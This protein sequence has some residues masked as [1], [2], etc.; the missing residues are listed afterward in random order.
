MQMKTAHRF[1]K[2]RYCQIARCEVPISPHPH[3]LLA[4]C[5]HFTTVRWTSCFPYR[6]IA[7][8]APPALSLRSV[9]VR[10]QCWSTR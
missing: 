6:A 4:D 10:G 1:F 9:G 8:H 5:Y 7:I 3:H 2:F